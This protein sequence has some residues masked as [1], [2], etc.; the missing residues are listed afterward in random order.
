[1]CPTGIILPK[2]IS[3][4]ENVAIAGHCNLRLPGLPPDPPPPSH[5]S[6]N[7]MPENRTWSC[8]SV[9]KISTF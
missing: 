6:G 5:P 8:L 7:V 1:M 2:I 4:L 9:R 3:K